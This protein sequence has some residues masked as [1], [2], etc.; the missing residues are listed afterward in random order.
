MSSS[1]FCHPGVFCSF[2]VCPSFAIALTPYTGICLLQ[3]FLAPN[4]FFLELPPIPRASSCRVVNNLRST[5]IVQIHHTLL[6]IRQQALFVGEMD[7]SKAL[8]VQSCPDLLG[9]VQWAS[10]IL[11]GCKT[12]ITRYDKVGGNRRS[13]KAMGLGG[14]HNDRK[15]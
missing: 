14:N 3:I 4:A 8:L 7:Y 11:V 6:Y 15:D 13:L 9:R 12:F 1:S 10:A 5:R 2:S